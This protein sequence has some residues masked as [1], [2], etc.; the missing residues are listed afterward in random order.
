MKKNCELLVRFDSQ[1]GSQNLVREICSTSVHDFAHDSRSKLVSRDLESK[2]RDLFCEYSMH[3]YCCGSY[4][5]VDNGLDLVPTDGPLHSS[6]QSVLEIL[7]F[8]PKNL[9]THFRPSLYWVQQWWAYSLAHCI[10]ARPAGYYSDVSIWSGD[11]GT[12]F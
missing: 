1:N 7:L 3:P 5:G 8:H 6:I 2:F 10:S 9:D 11:S 4:T 12:R